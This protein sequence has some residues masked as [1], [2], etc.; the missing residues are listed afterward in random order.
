ML[1]KAWN[2]LSVSFTCSIMQA[3]VMMQQEP[4]MAITG[5]RLSGQWAIDSLPVWV[6]DSVCLVQLGIVT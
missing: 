5:K 1:Q 3:V 6:S 2:N 4:K